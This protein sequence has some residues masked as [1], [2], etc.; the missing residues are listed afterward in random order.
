[1][2]FSLDS[3]KSALAILLPLTVITIIILVAT[4]QNILAETRADATAVAAEAV[5]MPRETP[6]SDAQAGTPADTAQNAAGLSKTA[7]NTAVAGVTL[8][9]VTSDAPDTS[10]PS[11]TNKTPGNGSVVGPMSLIGYDFSDPSG[12]LWPDAV[13][14]YIDRVCTRSLSGVTDVT[15]GSIRYTPTAPL[16]DGPH[17]IKALVYDNFFN[18]GWSIW[19]ITVDATAPTASG[20]DPTGTI[21]VSAPTIT[22]TLS[23]GTGSGVNAS[24]VTVTLGV[25]DITSSCTATPTSVSCNPGALGDGNHTVSIDI[26]DNAGNHGATSWNFL[27]DTAAIGV[28]NQQPADAS[29]QT[30]ATPQISASFQAVGLAV[31]QTGEVRILVNGID[32]TS[33]TTKTTIDTTGVRYLPGLLADGNHTVR[34]TVRDNASHSGLSEW[35]FNIDTTAPAVTQD[36]PGGNIGGGLP[37]FTAHYSDSGS[38][39]NPA[40]VRV[41]ID[42]DDA[43]ASATV[44]ASDV[45]FTPH[46]RLSAGAHNVQVSVSD[47][48]C[49]SQTSTWNISVPASEQQSHLPVPTPSATTAIRLVEYWQ[50]YSPISIGSSGSGWVISGFA[51]S[52]N[53]YFLPWYDS[54]PDGGGGKSEL[55]IANRG[56]GEAY[57]SIFVAGQEKWHGN[58]AE[59]SEEIRE[60]ADTAGGPVK[61]ICP[62]G[63]PL[64]VKLR[65]S[66]GSSVSE[67]RAT[68]GEDLEPVWL[69]PWY[70]PH[71]ENSSGSSRLFIANA[72]DTK[73]AVDVYLGDPDLPESLKG[74]YSIQAGTAAVAD[75]QDAGSGLVRV[76][77]TNGQPLIVG[78]QTT[79]GNSF[80]QLS[81]AGLSGL[82]SRYS[83]DSY[84]SRAES[85]VHGDWLLLGN[86]MNEEARVE[87]S[88]GGR[89]MNDPENPGNDF[90]LLPKGGARELQFPDT[91]GSPVE[92]ICTNCSF[93]QGFVAA[94]RVIKNQSISEAI[95]RPSPLMPYGEL[96]ED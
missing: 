77:S 1:M 87:I 37:S 69:I 7:S 94:H 43:T 16:T 24:G 82:D 19:S 63:Q 31:I 20:G 18:G 62:T 41:S 59:G 67:T 9:P 81:A 28:T 64:D 91:S 57:V 85:G 45:T 15:A 11:I 39:I 70:Q 78:Q 54:R 13:H 38:G 60:L 30:S 73:A 75:L 86:G 71:T 50:S 53:S 17:T 48:A 5:Y 83:F 8:T 21:N 22:A 80:S 4:P 44:G 35:D 96:S 40:S 26:P 65:I 25:S 90:F 74:H 46:S 61:I 89:R 32:V 6:G 93:G 79:V 95:G 29:W 66:S 34:V 14:I 36:A 84:D 52:P 49:N 56:G 55:V 76:S 58:L 27:V 92:V 68:T 88:I 47:N 2:K 23:D 3:C 51:A 33:E 12:V 72:G 42:G 10:P